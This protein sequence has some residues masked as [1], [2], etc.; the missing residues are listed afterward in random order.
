MKCP[1]CNSTRCK[2][3]RSGKYC[4]DCG[5]R[6]HKVLGRWETGEF[7]ADMLRLVSQ[8]EEVKRR[9]DP[10]FWFDASDKRKE[11]VAAARLLDKCKKDFDV[12]SYMLAQSLAGWPEMDSILGVMARGFSSR[13]ARAVRAVRVKREETQRNIEA[14]KLVEQ[15]ENVFDDLETNKRPL[16]SNAA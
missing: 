2:T 5:E 7:Y 1:Y 10:E 15:R 16:Y 9:Q 11:K 13:R 8:F 14:A 6:V 3:L 4:R 12:A